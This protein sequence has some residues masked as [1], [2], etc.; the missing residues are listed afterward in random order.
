MII[1]L[2]ISQSWLIGLYRLGLVVTVATVAWLAFT[3]VPAKVEL[4]AS[5]KANH[6]FAFFVLAWLL[7]N[8]FTHQRFLKLKLWPLLAYGIVIEIVQYFVGRDCSVLDLGADSAGI[9]IYWLIR[10]WARCLLQAQ[11]DGI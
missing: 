6:A 4:V 5:D 11:Q 8:A 9:S 10:S 1:R 7:D 3:P 2:P